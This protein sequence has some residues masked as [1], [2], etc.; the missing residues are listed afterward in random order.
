M[1]KSILSLSISIGLL[2]IGFSQT[3]FAQ[4]TTTRT[5]P[6]GNSQVTNRTYG[7]GQQTTTRTGPKGNS[8]VTNRTY[9]NGQQTTTRTGPKG[10]SQV[11]NRSISH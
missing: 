10:N 7:N 5:G 4:Q 8:Q 9:G 2:V 6:N 1:Q 11:T 3:A